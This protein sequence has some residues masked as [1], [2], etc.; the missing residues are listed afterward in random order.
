[1][2][3]SYSALDIYQTCP[4]KYKFRSIDKIPVPTRPEL[5]FGDLIHQIIA[6][7]LGSE[8]ILPLDQILSLYQEKWE[9]EIFPSQREERALFQSGLIMLKNFYQDHKP[10]LTQIVCIEKRFSIPLGNH[11]LVGK[12]DRI[13]KLPHGTFQV[14]DYK[15]SKNLPTQ[16]E[17]EK[18]LQL[19]IYH[20][21]TIYSWP[22]VEKIRLTL[23]FLKHNQK[24]T[25]QRN[26]IEL[27]LIKEE[28]IKTADK[29]EDDIQKGLDAFFPR[30]GNYCD[31]CD[32]TQYCPM[33]KQKTTPEKEEGI[34]DLIDQYLD[35]RNQ[36]TILEKKIHSHFDKEKIER[37]FHKKGIITRRGKRFS[38]KK[39]E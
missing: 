9:P 10:G 32:Y 25:T 19:G 20:L 5:Y 15:T 33:R 16:Q 39:P 21:A 2:R 35:L 6:Q 30:P 8:P 28:I 1:M 18:D 23:Y 34:K 14:I 3:I 31:W 24:L 12:I 22:E 13:D 27:N 36:Q 7:A 37:Y 26:E 11:I 4:L 38:L 17:I 29:I